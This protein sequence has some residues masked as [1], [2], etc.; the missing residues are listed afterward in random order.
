MAPST[1]D[2]GEATVRYRYT[3]ASPLV[4]RSASC[5]DQLLLSPLFQLSAHSNMERASSCGLPFLLDGFTGVSAMNS[6]QENSDCCIVG[7]KA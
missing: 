5:V 6:A 1:R 3:A 4:S 2:E 7:F